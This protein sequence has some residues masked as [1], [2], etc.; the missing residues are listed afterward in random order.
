MAT[1]WIIIAGMLSD[2]ANCRLDLQ[3]KHTC[4]LTCS[5]R[6]ASIGELATSCSVAIS[7]LS[8]NTSLKAALEAIQAAYKIDCVH[9]SADSA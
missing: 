5:L 3:S 1:S 9:S 4:R 8:D 2:T 6:A 7:M